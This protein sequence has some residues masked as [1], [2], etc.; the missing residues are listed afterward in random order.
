MRLKGR[1]KR[2]KEKCT[3]ST[4]APS[5][6]VSDITIKLYKYPL[7]LPL[8]TRLRV[9]SYMQKYKKKKKKKNRLMQCFAGG[10]SLAHSPSNPFHYCLSY[11]P[12]LHAPRCPRP[13]EIKNQMIKIQNHRLRL[14]RRGQSTMFPSMFDSSSFLSFFLGGGGDSSQEGTIL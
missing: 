14:H 13:K 5:R 8:H 12:L 11:I 10:Y 2:R 7:H 3:F 6:P 9:S 4:C 1:K